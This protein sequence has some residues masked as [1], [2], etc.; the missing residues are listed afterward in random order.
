M[1][2]TACR[3][4]FFASIKQC[5]I[6]RLPNIWKII[7][8]HCLTHLVLR[9]HSEISFSC[10]RYTLHTFVSMLQQPLVCQDLLIIEVALS[11]L[12]TNFGAVLET[13]L[14]SMQRH[15]PDNIQHLKEKNFH[16]TSG[17]RTHN[18][19]RRATADSRLRTQDHWYRCHRFMYIRILYVTFCEIN[20]V[21]VLLNSATNKP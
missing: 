18:L 13:T 16:A 15:L 10:H 7:Q 2:C 4:N 21:N 11:H 9:F 20:L 5:Y 14:C 8:I 3:V 19:S 1:S 17:I 6:K 12:D